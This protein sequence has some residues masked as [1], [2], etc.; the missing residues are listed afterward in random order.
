MAAPAVPS[1]WS[2]LAMEV[3]LGQAKEHMLAF[4][5]HKAVA[6]LQQVHILHKS[7]S[8]LRT[9]RHEMRITDQSL[10][11]KARVQCKCVKAFRQNNQVKEHSSAKDCLLQSILSAAVS[12]DCKA[13]YR[14]ATSPCSCGEQKL[15][16]DQEV[17]LDALDKLAACSEFLKKPEVAIRFAAAAI[18]LCPQ[19]PVVC[20]FN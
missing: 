3:A 5:Y 4:R 19:S 1:R 15:S 6:L 7:S 14:A 17:H 11:Y 8:S 2:P 9:P 12:R 16:C 20:P 18:H 10:I 13:V